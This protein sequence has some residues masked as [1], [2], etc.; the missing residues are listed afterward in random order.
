MTFLLEWALS[1]LC[2][3]GLLAVVAA[4]L[5]RFSRRPALL[6]ALWLLVLLKL[7]TPPLV[8][9]SIGWP[10]PLADNSPPAAAPAPPQ[11]PVPE[12]P[13]PG[14]GPAA[15]MAAPVP[16]A[17]RQPAVPEVVILDDG[18][19][20]DLP[21]A[22]AEAPGVPPA[23]PAIPRTSPGQSV[24]TPV[25]QEPEAGQAAKAG[26]PSAP[27]PPAEAGNGAARSWRWQI[28]LGW[29]WL[30][31]SALWLVVA[32]QRLRQFQ[33]LLQFAQPTPPAIQAESRRL[34]RRLGVAC[35]QIWLLPGQLTPM[36]WAL[37][38]RQGLLLPA[39]L[40]TRLTPAQQATLIAHELAHLRR[41]DHWVRW[42]E[43][44]VLGLYWWCPLV[45]WARRELREAEEDCCDAWVLWALPGAQRDY[46]LALVETVDF[47]CQA[48]PAAPLLAS[49]LGQVRHLRRRLTM[50]MRGTTPRAL[51]LAGS[52]LVL[53]AAVLLLP[54][55]PS[56]AQPP[57][58]KEK[59][60][61]KEGPPFKKEF[62]DK[63][64]PDKK[65]FRDKE[66]P[67]A[68]RIEEELHRIK[69]ELDKHR[70]MAERRAH[71]LREA[72]ERIKHKKDFEPR[73]E[74]EGRPPFPP[75]RPGFGPP[76][77]LE[78]RL[79][80]I[81]KKLDIMLFA[82]TQLSKEMHRPGPGREF[83][84]PP[85]RDF[86]GPPGEKRDRDF[87]GPP[88]RGERKGPPPERRLDPKERPGIEKQPP[89]PERVNE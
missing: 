81:E 85:E 31:G 55:W 63:E 76:H 14:P 28:A 25:R 80:E 82:I 48:P 67:D 47:L 30:L 56:W 43:L 41:R 50:I 54:L 29:A 9:F 45:W 1:N 18:P 49:G 58:D 86:K 20:I 52:L 34:A 21:V 71:E 27:P 77:E 6:H 79:N 32:G 64:R 60:F 57:R 74:R 24:A 2:M 53:G 59:E 70:E 23:P 13:E 5:S 11:T 66:Q 84:G 37:G 10:G 19:D 65:E 38:T 83:K 46:A 73:G 16:P 61:K 78:R 35:P 89:Q 15:R 26:T 12:A 8:P 17:F 68:Q 72:L 51:T 36:L 40:L 88:E 87:K 44:I 62:R 69:M 39:D 3:A 75:D 4:V 22:M 42:L 7:V 33:S